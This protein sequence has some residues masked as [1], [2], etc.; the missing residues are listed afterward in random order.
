M[1]NASVSSLEICHLSL[2]P[3]KRKVRG[4]EE[5]AEA[6]GHFD[7]TEVELVCYS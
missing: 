6:S 4:E 1:G 2:Q 3:E 5:E 7:K